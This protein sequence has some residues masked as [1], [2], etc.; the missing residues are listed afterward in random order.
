MREYLQ[1]YIDGQWVEPSGI[2]TWEVI[3]PAT[4]E[5]SGRIALGDAQDVDRAANAARRAFK[6]FS[7]TSREERVALLERVLTEFEARIPDLEAAVS[8]EMGSP[9]WVSHEAQVVLPHN[10][11]KIAIE[12]LKSYD[13]LLYTSPSPRD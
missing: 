8:E 2:K 11:L 10:H 4:E 3:N 6:T 12:N 1:F 13:C 7:R 5:P 9:Q